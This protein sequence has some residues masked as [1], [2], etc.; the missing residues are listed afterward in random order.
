MVDR[1]VPLCLV[2]LQTSLNTHQQATIKSHRGKRDENGSQQKHNEKT[3]RMCPGGWLLQRK[4]NPRPKRGQPITCTSLQN[5]QRAPKRLHVERQE[6]LKALFEQSDDW[7]TQFDLQ[8]HEGATSD[9]KNHGPF[10]AHIA[11]SS[12]RP[13]GLMWSDK[14]NNDVDRADVSVGGKHDKMVR[15]KTW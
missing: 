2:L 9:L 1:S 5:S 8:P 4:A 6:V 12:R 13:D 14:L 11:T 3:W 15:R 7:E 10:P